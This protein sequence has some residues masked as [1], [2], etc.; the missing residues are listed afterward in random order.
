MQTCQGNIVL[1]GSSKEGIDP[2]EGKGL[3]LDAD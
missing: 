3:D 1:L 2:G